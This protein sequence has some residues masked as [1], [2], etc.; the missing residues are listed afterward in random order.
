MY[1]L[2]HVELV[3]DSRKQFDQSWEEALMALEKEPEANLW[4]GLYH[5]QLEN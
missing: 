3:N 5:R 2:L 4:E 1:D